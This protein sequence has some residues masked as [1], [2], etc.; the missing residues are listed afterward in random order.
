MARPT[1]E[2][3]TLRMQDIAPSEFDLLTP[4]S[5][6][7]LFWQPR[8][9]VGS[10]ALH[11]LP[12]LFWLVETLRPSRAVQIGIG[13]G[14]GYFGLCQAV[15]KLG[16]DTACIGLDWP[17][18]DK[19]APA[20]IA[21]HQASHYADISR[22]LAEDPASAHRHIRG[23]VDLLI[24]NTPLTPALIE[25]LRSHWQPLLSDRAVLVVPGAELDSSDAQVR[26]FLA[27]FVTGCP[28]VELDIEGPILTVL[29]GKDQPDRLTR[30]AGLEMGRAGY[31]EARQVFSRLGTGLRQEQLAKFRTL[32][33][34]KARSTLT[35]LEAELAAQKAQRAA[36]LLER[37]TAL[38]AEADTAAFAAGLQVRLFDQDQALHQALAAQAETLT[39]TH[40]AE[41]DRLRAQFTEDLRLSEE[42]LR[43][44]EEKR[45]AHWRSLTSQTEARNAAE[46]QLSE[47]TKTLEKTKAALAQ[48]GAEAET[49]IADIA[50]LTAHL[51]NIKARAAADAEAAAQNH[52]RTEQALQAEVD[53]LIGDVA[54]LTAYFEAQA[55]EAAAALLAAQNSTAAAAT[56]MA[57]EY[58]R[59]QAETEGRIRQLQ[60]DL[61]TQTRALKRLQERLDEAQ[62]KRVSHFKKLEAET[63]R[64]ALLSADLAEAKARI[65]ALQAS[66][67]WKVTSP[68]RKIRGIGHKS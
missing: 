32:E 3:E 11:A 53:T 28:V 48:T 17:A 33:V 27:G 46:L 29:L 58:A 7:A 20:A 1:R 34:K 47:L 61:G 65:A 36:T 5:S 43:L 51:E 40:S 39:A 14:V 8:F 22:I 13:D 44:S 26:A 12:Y 62:E 6:R 18:R 16:L 24:L 15:D 10:D 19:S 23:D 60:A 4:L 30:L 55:Q 67:S 31:A 35:E 42:N 2:V 56:Q 49:R 57:A 50:E 38:A 45:T 64:N 52:A 9:V 54:A 25:T 66:T 41:L 37:D 63:A 59:T 21:D 68:L